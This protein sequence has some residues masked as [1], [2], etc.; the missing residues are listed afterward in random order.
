MPGLNV[1]LRQ[2]CSLADAAVLL[3]LCLVAMGSRFSDALDD[4]IPDEFIQVM[5]RHS[6]SDRLLLD[7]ASSWPNVALPLVGGVLMDKV[8]GPKGGLVFACSIIAVGSTVVSIAGSVEA[9]AGSNQAFV[10]SMIGWVFFS[11]GNVM[12]IGQQACAAQ[13]FRGRYFATVLSVMN[14]FGQAS[15]AMNFATMPTLAEVLGF[16]RALWIATGLCYVSV[17]AALVLSCVTLVDGVTEVGGEREAERGS[18][19][20]LEYELTERLLLRDREQTSVEDQS[21][22]GCGYAVR[23]AKEVLLDAFGA[24]EWLLV[25]VCVLIY[26]CVHQFTSLG[27]KLLERTFHLSEKAAS[28]YVAFPLAFEAVS[29]PFVSYAI[30]IVGYP[31]RWLFASTVALTLVHLLFLLPNPPDPRIIVLL[32]GVGRSLL[33][34]SLWPMVAYLFP[35]RL[36]ATGY[37]LMISFQNIGLA[38]SPIVIGQMLPNYR[39]IELLVTACGVAATMACVG[40]TALDIAQGGKLQGVPRRFND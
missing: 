13:R 16:S 8:L 37:G 11:F 12:Y 19:C 34:A 35:E 29:L 4:S 22:K 25:V 21:Q 24:K 36:V 39:A 20:E 28:A 14:C 3:L 23:T 7:S 30:D 38:V 33:S 31:L 18:E 40:V 27:C 15:M 1:S 6:A 32:F 5:T 26:V 2:G 9:W 17:V 10:L